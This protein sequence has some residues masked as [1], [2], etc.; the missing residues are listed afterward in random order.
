MHRARVLFLPLLC[1]CVLAALLVYLSPVHEAAGEPA[2]GGASARLSWRPCSDSL[3]PVSLPLSAPSPEGRLYIAGADINAGVD[4]GG[5]T[6]AVYAESAGET[7]KW[8]RSLLSRPMGR[9]AELVTTV[10]ARVAGTAGGVWRE[11]TVIDGG[12]G[13]S[14]AMQCPGVELDAA[15][16]L[17]GGHRELTVEFGHVPG[18]AHARVGFCARPQASGGGRPRIGACLAPLTYAVRPYAVAEWVEYHKLLGVS[19]FW[20]YD[21][22]EVANKTYAD[23]VR[24]L[25]I[26]GEPGSVVVRRVPFM[27][28][29]PE[30][31]RRSLYFWDQRELLAHCLFHAR[32]EVDLVTVWDMDEFLDDPKGRFLAGL[33][34]DLERSSDGCARIRFGHEIGPYPQNVSY[35]PERLLLDQFRQP[36]RKLVSPPKMRIAKD[37]RS[38]STRE[39]A[40][41]AVRAALSAGAQSWAAEFCS[42]G[43]AHA[44]AS[45]AAR[46]CAHSPGGASDAS[47]AGVCACA[48]SLATACA[49]SARDKR[50]VAAVALCA[51]R[52]TAEARAAALAYLAASAA[53][54]AEWQRRVVAALHGAAGGGP[55]GAWGPVAEALAASAGERRSAAALALACVCGA[56][57][58][59]SR[60]GLLEEMLGVDGADVA[61]A[62][63]EEGARRWSEAL[64]ADAE[65]RASIS[66]PAGASA[67]DAGELARLAAERVVSDAQCKAALLSVLRSLD[68]VRVRM[69]DAARRAALLQFNE[70]DRRAAVKS[71]ALVDYEKELHDQLR[72]ARKKVAEYKK[73]EEARAKEEERRAKQAKDGAAPDGVVAQSRAVD[74]LRK[75]NAVA[76]ERIAKLEADLKH[77]RKKAAAAVASQKAPQQAAAP[78]PE[79]VKQ[80]QSLKEELAK[81]KSDAVAA[82]RAAKQRQTVEAQLRE[83]LDAEKASR[84]KAE[85]EKVAAE[86]KAN[87]LAEAARRTDVGRGAELT[88]AQRRLAELEASTAAMRAASEELE[89][90]RAAQMAECSRLRDELAAT[91][92]L[93]SKAAE[94]EAALQA[95]SNANEQHKREE[96]VAKEESERIKRENASLSEQLAAK[97]AEADALAAKA[98]EAQN[99]AVLAQTGPQAQ[100]AASATEIARLTRELEAALA[101]ERELNA[102]KSQDAQQA[103]S[104]DT[105]RS[106]LEGVRKELEAVIQKLEK[107]FAA[108]AAAEKKADPAAAGGKAQAIKLLDPKKSQNISITLS[109]VKAPV[110]ELVSAVWSLDSNTLGP[111][112][113]TNFVK[114]VPSSEEAEMLKEHADERA[115]LDRPEQFL[116]DLSEVPRLQQRAESLLFQ[117]QFGPKL[118]ETAPGC[119]ALLS[120]CSQVRES[121]KFLRVLEVVLALGNFIN[122]G[123]V[124]GGLY[125]YRLESLT[126]LSELR[127]SSDPKY[128]LMHALNEMLTEHMSDAVDWWNDMSAIEAAR[129][130]PL[131]QQQADLASLRKGLK[132]LENE[133]S[134]YASVPNKPEKDKFEQVMNAFLAESK[135]QF[136]KVEAT[137]KAAEESFKKT[138]EFFGEDPSMTT[139]DF[140]AAICNFHTAFDKAAKEIKDNQDK[141]DKAAKMAEKKAAAPAVG[142]GRG[143]PGNQP[144]VA[145]EAMAM[146]GQPKKA[147]PTDDDESIDDLLNK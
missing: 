123:S 61:P 18:V 31:V 113:I 121:K 127:S 111:V 98:M 17:R 22:T 104:A 140:F 71:G 100:D 63:D 110:A 57:D 51:R 126:Q 146:F 4:R 56:P 108:K 144:A 50:L 88:A 48:A 90:Q 72:D 7:F 36:V 5:A 55:A 85:S 80:L 67:G 26:G 89:R 112:F 84:T 118:A 139:E 38:S 142:R 10:L 106:S 47:V 37:L 145:M 75:E 134:E 19:K 27:S 103:V 116:L 49:E 95:A 15:R 94:L 40:I 13:S 46:L 133:L 107:L 74:Q 28:Q 59:A 64:G 52:V 34:R 128:T 30:N 44:L 21:R 60:R 42:A 24:E 147:L 138:V 82:E 73:A 131:T 53:G 119:E 35:D 124:R 25:G 130:S 102:A 29:K 8:G 77:E 32:G 125:G 1:L 132:Q 92:A 78:D 65:Y 122:A 129:R 136:E 137:F 6:F 81:T 16:M 3:F 135:A 68:K 70:A 120:A 109:S 69:C 83:Q 23:V 117:M 97:K 141:A 45:A 54:G 101:R 41:R 33:W 87:D 114:C 143:Q 43:G 58:A 14:M 11:C 20:I 91:S 105:M 2:S 96:H 93:K 9:A 115:A 39:S 79:L 12:R 62:L 99:K 66:G 86:Q 76:A